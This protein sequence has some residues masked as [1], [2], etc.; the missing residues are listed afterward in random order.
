MGEYL[1]DR[2]KQSL[3]IEDTEK[4]LFGEGTVAFY[5]NKNLI[6]VQSPRKHK[7]CG[8]IVIKKEAQK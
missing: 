1:C 5:E 2:C 7:I 4:D 3:R 8:G 6:G